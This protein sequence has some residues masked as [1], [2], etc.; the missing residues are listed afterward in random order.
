MTKEI[1]MTK[2][3]ETTKATIRL[4]VIRASSLV[5]HASFAIRHFCD[6]D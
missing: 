3:E 1:Q 4:F 2:P 5:R 6:A